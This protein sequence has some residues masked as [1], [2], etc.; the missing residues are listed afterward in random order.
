MGFRRVK[1]NNRT[2]KTTM[3]KIEDK[4]LI[5]PAII[6]ITC[7][8][9]KSIVGEDD[10]DEFQEFMSHNYFAGY[11]NTVFNDGDELEVDLCQH[12]V[13]S[14]LGP[15]MRLVRNPI[16]GFGYP[17]HE[18]FIEAIKNTKMDHQHDHLNEL[19]DDNE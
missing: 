16:S 6:Q 13:K 18:E 10:I 2:P 12:C 1:Q 7:D 5:R 19:L 15:Y 11:G 17:S 3:R 14:L 4:V 9:C 8:C